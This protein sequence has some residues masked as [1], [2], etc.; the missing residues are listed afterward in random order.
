MIALGALLATSFVAGG[1][2]VL[3]RWSRRDDPKARPSGPEST[4]ARR[5]PHVWFEPGSVVDKDR[6]AEAQ[7][8]TEPPGE[9]AD[10]GDFA[11][12]HS[13]P[14]F[15]FELSGGPEGM[16]ESESPHGLAGMDNPRSLSDWIR[17]RR[18]YRGH[19]WSTNG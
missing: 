6:F 19:R 13:H 14:T 17:R 11:S 15:S 2:Y 18:S 1:M 12:E 7:A 8:S 16:P 4:P 10:E 5:Y 9:A 3:S